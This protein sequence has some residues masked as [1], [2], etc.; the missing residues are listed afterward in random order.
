[1]LAETVAELGGRYGLQI[2][3]IFNNETTHESCALSHGQLVWAF[4]YMRVETHGRKKEESGT[5]KCKHVTHVMSTIQ[6]PVL[7]DVL[8]GTFENKNLFL[9]YY[10]S[11]PE[12][13]FS[14]DISYFIL[15]CDYI[16]RSLNK[17]NN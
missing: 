17:L 15:E 3:Y 10:L 14:K 13:L 5:Q 4:E 6:V 1:L 11:P 2:V 12:T 7:N 16:I 9:A 8:F